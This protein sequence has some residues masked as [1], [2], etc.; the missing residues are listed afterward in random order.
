ML[1]ASARS[2]KPVTYG[3]P[4]TLKQALDHLARVRPSAKPLPKRR[5]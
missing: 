4:V 1:I 3:K 2:P 5:R